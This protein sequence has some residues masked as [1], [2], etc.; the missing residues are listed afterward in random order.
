MVKKTGGGL[1]GYRRQ[2]R[3]E[4]REAL[5]KTAESIFAEQGYTNSS[6]REVADATPLSTA[7]LYKICKSKEE[8]L[9][10]VIERMAEEETADA[11][12]DWIMRLLIAEGNRIVQDLS[13]ARCAK[14]AS[15]TADTLKQL[16]GT[17]AP[18]RKRA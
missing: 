12:Q 3:K 11:V 13:H 4:K 17:A 14:A 18:K 6:V 5:L 16:S 7:T 8:L 10:A 1:E 2:I 9:A 15:L